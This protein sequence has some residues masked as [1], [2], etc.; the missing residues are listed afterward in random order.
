MLSG[1]AGQAGVS[2]SLRYGRERIRRGVVHFLL[3][4]GISAVAGLAVLILLVRELPVAEFATY[5][6]LQAFV[7]VFTA[8]TGFGLTHAALRYVPELYAQH[9]NK[10]FRGFVMGAVGL[11]LAFLTLACLL[12]YAAS[13]GL[14]R[15][16][17]LADWVSVLQAYLAVVWV[18][19]NGHFLFQLLE[20]TLHQGLGQAAFVMST[21]LKLGFISWFAL[22]GTLNIEIVIWSEVAAETLGLGVLLMGVLRVLR[23]T[24]PEPT[25]QG[26]AEWWSGNARRV[27]RYGFAG[28][29]QHL[30]ILPYGSAPNR[31]VAGRFLEVSALAAFGFAQSFTDMLRGYLPA[32]F[33]AGLIR[34]VLTARFSTTRDFG[35]VARVLAMVFRL[36]TV[37]L[38]AVA[39][40]LLALG[41]IAVATLSGGKYGADAAWLLFALVGVLVLESHRFL[42]ALAVQTVERNGLLIT[43]NL[44]LAASLLLSIML[45]PY[46]GAL[47]IPLTAAVGLVA[48]NAWIAYRLGKEGF[49]Y[50]FGHLDFGRV[51][52]CVLIAAL[53]GNTAQDMLGW[54]FGVVMIFITYPLLLWATGA[55]R[56]E[57]LQRLRNFKQ[58]STATSNGIAPG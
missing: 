3:G 18:R 25:M 31:L 27:T 44:A 39:A 33:M 11:R 7:E 1:F 43:G 42:I 52:L 20:S 9:E 8:F 21:V 58:Q 12:A 50:T 30:A 26:M 49:V 16:F 51:L 36:N 23:E 47:A 41:P 55:I 45:I 48:S 2:H 46:V 19:V 32:Q 15:L 29:L 37:F 6:V 17:G 53:I 4:K 56:R 40:P 38:G 13:D 28:Y 34:P 14:A 35:E 54:V 5:S 10:A 24:K 57:D 22:H